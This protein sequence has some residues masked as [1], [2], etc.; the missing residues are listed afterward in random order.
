MRLKCLLSFSIEDEGTIDFKEFVNV[1]ENYRSLRQ[2]D[3]AAMF[4]KVFDS[5]HRG[6]IEGKAIKRSLQFLDDVPI[7]EINEILTKTK[8]TDDQKITIEGKCPLPPIPENKFPYELH[9]P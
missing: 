5:E 8:L 2:D 7:N 1:M 9:I 3:E 6:F 4:F